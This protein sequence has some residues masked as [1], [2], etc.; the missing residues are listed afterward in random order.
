MKAVTTEQI[1]HLDERTIAAGIPAIELMERA[2]YA[3]AR[4]TFAL[5]KKRDARSVL[6]FAGKGNNGGDAFVAARHLASAGC[7]VTL[8]LLCRRGELRGA[9]LHHFQQ[10]VGVK[11]L[12][13]PDELPAAAVIVDGLL[14]TGFTGVVRE[15][16]AAAIEFM[17]HQS[18]PIVAIDVPSGFAV[19][20][21]VTVTIGLPK[22]ELLKN[23]DSAGR[24]E[25][26]DIG[27]SG[28][29][30]SDIELIAPGDI[31][32]PARRR[33]MH[34][35]D[36]GHL[37]IIAGSE[38]YTGAPVLCAHAAAR[39][40]VGLVT[41][42]VPREIYPIVA[43]QCPPEIMPCPL[44][45]VTGKFDAVAI[46][47]GLRAPVQQ[48]FSTN[49]VLDAGALVPEAIRPGVVITPHPGEMGRLI[50]KSATEVQATRWETARQ[51][52]RDKRVTLVLKGAGTVVTDAA[53]PLWIN[54]TGNPGMAKG[55]MGDALTGII[56]ALLAQG[57]PALEAAKVGV[58]LHGLAGDLAADKHGS[59]S[60]VT[61]DLINNLG[62]AFATFE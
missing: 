16:Y 55:G 59:R 42:A 52:A 46:G 57:L 11:V 20:A 27:L 62:A 54:A 34:K 12:E 29:V 47:P 14:G 8:T 24:I 10:L 36:C 38:G 1:R 3:V 37:L 17:N 39:A 6:L 45:S 60:M 32:L 15:P 18:A 22:I 48:D 58:Y 13:W 23:L 7:A 9:A 30:V 49:V 61:T 44:E 5:L 40:G 19:R 31:H 41:L 35:G 56:G 2:G 43:A 25:V 53:S 28:D 51:F 4:T 21:T 26:A 50:G 33:S